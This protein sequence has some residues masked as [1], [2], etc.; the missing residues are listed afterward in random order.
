[1]GYRRCDGRAQE[2]SCWQYDISVVGPEGCFGNFNA[3]PGSDRLQNDHVLGPFSSEVPND[4]PE[5]LL[6]FCRNHHLRVGGSWFRKKTI[7]RQSWYSNDGTATKE[8]DCYKLL[9]TGEPFCLASSIYLHSQ[10]AHSG[11]ATPAHSTFLA[12]SLKLA[13]A[14]SVPQLHPFGLAFIG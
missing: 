9:S 2:N 13:R 10:A 12:T 7:H 8:I 14:L 11:Q 1:M 4:N 3:V 6:A 5:R